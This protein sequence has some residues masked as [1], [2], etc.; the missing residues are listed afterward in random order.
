MI[1]YRRSWHERTIILAGM[2]TFNCAYWTMELSVCSA[3]SAITGD[4]RSAIR[5]APLVSPVR[6]GNVNTAVMPGGGDDHEVRKDRLSNR[7]AELGFP[8]PRPAG[9]GRGR[10]ERAPSPVIPD[11]LF[12]V[13][14]VDR[15]AGRNRH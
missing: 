13:G 5:P 11:E 8:L 1:F 3:M 9:G 2:S 12:E 10:Q 7:L 14:R 6:L 4:R 15:R